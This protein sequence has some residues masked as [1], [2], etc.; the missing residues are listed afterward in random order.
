MRTKQSILYG[1]IAV[2]CALTFTVLSLTGCDNDITPGGGPNDP[3]VK[4]DL[5]VTW[6]AELTAA[7]GKKL[8]DISLEPYTNGN[9]G[10][11]AWAAP[12]QSVGNNIGIFK[13][14]MIFTPTDTSRHNTARGSVDVLVSMVD[15]QRIE[16]GSFTMGSP[17]GEPNRRNDE[18]QWEVALSSFYIGKYEITQK[19]Y[20]T[21]MGEKF[22]TWY[23]KNN[24]SWSTQDYG[25]GDDFPA[26]Y[27]S[28]YDALVFC[29]KLSMLEGLNPA[30]SINGSTNPA[31][32]GT[33]PTANDAA[34]NDVIVVADST[35]YRLPTEAQWAYACRAGTTTAWYF[36]DADG[37]EN[38]RSKDYA[39]TALNST[40][41]STGYITGKE[42]TERKTSPVGQKKPNAWGLY[43]M[44]G[45]VAELCWDWQ[46]TYPI[47]AR[48]NPMGASS[49]GSYNG[50]TSRGGSYSSSLANDRC[51]ARGSPYPWSR[52]G[53]L[54][55]ARPE[56]Y[57]PLEDYSM[58]LSA[59][60]YSA[61]GP[62]VSSLL[63]WYWSSAS[64]PWVYRNSGDIITIHCCGAGFPEGVYLLRGNVLITY[65]DK[66]EATYIAM[67]DDGTFY[68]RNTGTNFRKFYRGEQFLAGAEPSK[69]NSN[70]AAPIVVSNDLLG[71]WNGESGTYTFGSDLGLTIGTDEYAYL[72]SGKNVLI[73]GPLIDGQTTAL[74]KYTYI[75]SKNGITLIG[76]T[77]TITLSK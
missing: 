60:E 2:V 44:H 31:D 67:A 50:R 10:T 27:I 54:R 58:D 38:E 17:P 6:P 33:V 7:R 1:L 46:D 75:L 4:T 65:T 53:G 69:L 28:W 39:W 49:P 47:V 77:A 59:I 61:S 14:T 42:T 23:K 40:I 3:T 68:H 13:Y 34:W 56:G 20:E 63:G 48:L 8:A 45:N 16:A 35:G 15:M 74:Q 51:A 18:E 19:Q 37:N 9:T 25:Q 29:N 76:D 70:P 36:G 5:M 64:F 57:T 73:L 52:G 24:T 66:I 30:Y 12:Y 11:F 71:T 72:V 22:L 62:G 26:Y 43:D 21:V 41:T 32:W 55:V